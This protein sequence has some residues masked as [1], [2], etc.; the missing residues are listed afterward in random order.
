MNGY[1]KCFIRQCVCTIKLRKLN[2]ILATKSTQCQPYMYCK[3]PH[4]TTT[5]YPWLHLV[6][7]VTRCTPRS[8]LLSFSVLW[9]ELQYTTKGSTGSSCYTISLPIAMVTF[10][11]RSIYKVKVVLYYMTCTCIQHACYMLLHVHACGRHATM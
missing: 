1:I 3:S 7:V 8:K 9:E 4:P 2:H 5:Q 10:T 11:H 6:H